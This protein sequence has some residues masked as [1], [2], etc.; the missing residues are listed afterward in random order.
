L[1]PVMAPA[2]CHCLIRLSYQLHESCITLAR[3][4]SRAST[5]RLVYDIPMPDAVFREL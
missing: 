2:T 1:I 3:T 5:A 4:T